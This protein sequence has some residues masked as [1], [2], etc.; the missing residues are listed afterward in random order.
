MS[1]SHNS[2]EEVQCNCLTVDTMSHT[3]QVNKR[4]YIENISTIW[5][6]LTHMIVKESKLRLEEILK[7]LISMVHH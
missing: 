1:L 6:K 2:L 5:M 3:E 4:E 7:K